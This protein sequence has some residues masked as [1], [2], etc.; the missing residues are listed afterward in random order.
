MLTLRSCDSNKVEQ[1]KEFGELNASSFLL[2]KRKLKYYHPQVHASF[3]PSCNLNFTSFMKF[4]TVS[5]TSMMTS[6]T[7]PATTSD[8]FFFFFFNI[9]F[10]IITTFLVFL[11]LFVMLFNF[12]AF[13][14]RDDKL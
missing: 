5:I 2:L 11:Y 4:N 7:L 6:L 9:V 10:I 13:E 3:Y 8:F 1:V 12:S 14:A